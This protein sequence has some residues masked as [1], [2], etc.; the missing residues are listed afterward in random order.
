MSI[1]VASTRLSPWLGDLDLDL[2]A[3]L[4]ASVFSSRQ[5][6]TNSTSCAELSRGKRDRFAQHTHTV[7]AH[8]MGDPVQC[9]ALAQP[10]SRPSGL[11][12]FERAFPPQVLRAQPPLPRL[13]ARPQPPPPL[14]P[15]CPQACLPRIGGRGASPVGPS[16]SPAAISSV[17]AA[18]PT[19]SR[20]PTPHRLPHFGVRGVDRGLS[21]PVWSSCQPSGPWAEEGQVRGGQGLP[22]RPASGALAIR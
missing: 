12:S 1:S 13:P 2:V 7:G 16:L 17:P 11:G 15:Q 19:P 10:V 8:G 22:L 9:L 18:G 3:L 4:Q 21:S 14:C 20:S 5:V 6:G